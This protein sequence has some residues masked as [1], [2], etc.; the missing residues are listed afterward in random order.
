MADKGGIVQGYLVPHPPNLLEAERDGEELGTIRALEEIGKQIREAEIDVILA[1][2]SHWQPVGPF[3]V[4]ATDSHRHFTDY[5]G[6][7]V[8][9]EYECPGD[10]VLAK[11]FMEAASGSDLLADAVWKRGIDHGVSIPLHFMIPEGDIPV[12]PL[13]VSVRHPKECLEWGRVLNRVCEERGVK[14]AFV[15][16]SAL[17]HHMPLIAQPAAESRFRKFEEALIGALEDGSPQAVL[18]LD[19]ELVQEA[20][21]EGG[22]RD[23]M[24]LLGAM[25]ED[26]QGEVLS[27]EPFFGIGFATMQFT[28]GNSQ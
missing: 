23:V 3:F 13:S 11:E 16:S 10:Q 5:I 22:L 20:E 18:D 1:A 12:V 24:M 17:S 9:V 25:G 8:E 15:A 28:R 2:S 6:F 21:P 26:A 7:S 4:D 19:A 27:Y 14:A